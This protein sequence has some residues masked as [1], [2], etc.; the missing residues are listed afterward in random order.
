[1]YGCGGED[2]S[3]GGKKRDG[4]DEMGATEHRDSQRLRIGGRVNLG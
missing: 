3:R 2:W 4:T 1:M